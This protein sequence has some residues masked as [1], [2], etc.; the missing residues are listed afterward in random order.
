VNNNEKNGKETILI[1]NE[2]GGT[3]L[4]STNQTGSNKKGRNKSNLADQVALIDLKAKNPTPSKQASTIKNKPNHN[5][6]NNKKPNL[7]SE[8]DA[9]LFKNN[10][11]KIIENKDLESSSLHD[12]KND[13]QSKLNVAEKIKNKIYSAKKLDLKSNETQSI[14]GDNSKQLPKLIIKKDKNSS[15]NQVFYLNNVP[16]TSTS[17]QQQ[18]QQHQQFLETQNEIYNKKIVTSTEYKES[19][20]MFKHY[21]LSQS[22][23]ISPNS[24]FKSTSSINLSTKCKLFIT[25]LKY[26]YFSLKF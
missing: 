22:S 19:D 21:N 12:I 4:T 8:E 10:N 6:N 2:I 3:L 14:L 7:K 26:F 18:Q 16:Q 1:Q 9:S 11:N 20:E 25:T 5:N 13:D 15:N 23:L 24:K 17:Q